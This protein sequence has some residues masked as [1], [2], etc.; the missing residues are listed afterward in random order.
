MAIGMLRDDLLSLPGV[1]SAELEGDPITPS[2]IRV[3][4]SRGV[5]PAT[6]GAEVHRVL[7]Q[8]SLRPDDS[9]PPT[10][11]T[12]PAGRAAV[13]LAPAPSR[14]P[15]IREATVAAASTDGLP[16]QVAGLQSVSVSEGREG[17]VV[18]AAGDTASASVRAAGSSTPAIDQAVV[19]AVCELAATETVPF[20][21]SVDERDLGGTA[22]V[23]V[24]IEEGGDRLVG[25]AV[26]EAGRSYALGRAVWAALSSR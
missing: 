22:V 25:S 12:P 1:E 6:V 10:R 17:V 23:T 21:R 16:L 20:V 13:P 9:S 3:G 15:G 18:T 2:G 7:A 4:L 24:V 19:A 26:V 14:E 5:D 11:S 8:Y